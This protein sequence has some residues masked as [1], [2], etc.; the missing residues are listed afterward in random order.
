MLCKPTIKKITLFV[1]LFTYYTVFSQSHPDIIKG[2]FK[3]ALNS[4]GSAS[5]EVDVVIQSQNQVGSASVYY[6]QQQIHGIPIDKNQTTVVIK[7]N[8]ITQVDRQFNTTTAAKLRPQNTSQKQNSMQAAL[9]KALTLH[10]YQLPQT[11]PILTLALNQFQTWVVGYEAH[12]VFIDVVYA[13]TESGWLDL[14]YNIELYTADQQ[15]LFVVQILASSL[16]VSKNTL[17]TLNCT[18]AHH[19]HSNSSFLSKNTIAEKNIKADSGYLVFPFQ[20]PGPLQNTRQLLKN[21]AHPIASPFGWHDVD[22]FPGADYTITRGNNVYAY[23]DNKSENKPGYSPDGGPNLKFVFPF[24][25]EIAPPSQSTDAA[26]TNLFYTTNALHDL[27]YAFGF[28]ENSGNFQQNQ[29][30]RLN[31]RYLDGSDPLLAEAQDGSGVNNANISVP[32]DGSSPRIQMYLW[33]QDTADLV[34]V[35]EPEEIKGAYKSSTN[36]FDAGHVAVPVF[37]NGFAAKLVLVTDADGSNSGCTFPSNAN[38]LAGN[39]A[40]VVRGGCSFTE[41]VYQAQLAGAIAVVVM[42]NIPNEE[43]VTMSGSDNRITIPAVFVSYE[44]GNLWIEQLNKKQE[45]QIEI[46]QAI[47]RKIY[48]A[49]FDNSIIIHEFAHGVT[50]RLTGGRGN[51]SCLISAEQMGEGWSDYFS[52]LLQLKNGDSGQAP[53]GIG[54]YVSGGNTNA[55][56]IRRHPYSTDK[57]IN[58]ATYAITNRSF[59]TTDGVIKVNAHQVG[60]VWASILWDLTWLLLDDFGFDASFTNPTSGNYI[61]FQLVMNGLKLQPCNPSFITGRNAI[62]KADELLYNGAHSCKIWQAFA[63][64]G[65]GLHASA[66]LNEFPEDIKDQVEDFTRPETCNNQTNTIPEQPQIKVYPNPVLQDLFIAIPNYSS[67]IQV[68]LF[69]IHGKQLRS[70]LLDNF[71][72][73]ARLKMSDLAKGVYFV[74]IKGDKVDYQSKVI[75]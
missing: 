58:P 28:D 56:G 63:D 37:P 69:D 70:E 30:N 61:A 66:G 1:F 74:R 57:Q 47:H 4:S 8:Q 26:I 72:N 19:N 34:F 54:S 49:S 14:A 25:G 20:T 5:A 23:E 53:V 41:K 51:A 10:G 38:A 35:S 40:L 9:Q 59:T 21:P 29:Y 17:L 24:R 71:S 16:E 45:I 31:S 43:L 33:K 6:V 48:D 68:E 62:L 3:Q 75:K 32:R 13:Q 2:Y 7:N 39:I 12:P 11:K 67:T 18:A 27:F 42:N 50:S 36:A 44:T 52:L 65:V 73:I 15:Q 46:E 64:R 60:T 22:G 55:Q